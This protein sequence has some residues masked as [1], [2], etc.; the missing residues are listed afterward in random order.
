[1]PKQF[2]IGELVKY[3][4]YEIVRGGQTSHTVHGKVIGIKETKI[5]VETKDGER[6]WLPTC[7]CFPSEGRV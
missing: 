6:V 3:E 1:M 4:D 7:N 2:G 5:L